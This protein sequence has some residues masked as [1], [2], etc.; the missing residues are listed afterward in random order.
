MNQVNDAWQPLPIDVAEWMGLGDPF[1]RQGHMT[2]VPSARGWRARLR[3]VPQ[4]NEFSQ[5]DWTSPSGG[6]K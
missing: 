3:A 4:M 6:G 5:L 2:H 1:G